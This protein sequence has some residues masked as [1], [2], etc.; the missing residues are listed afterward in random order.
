MKGSHLQVLAIKNYLQMK[1][2]TSEWIR[3]KNSYMLNR[4]TKTAKVLN[5]LELKT[6]KYLFLFHLYPYPTFL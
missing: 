1:S 5:I 6:A 3:N 4:K 2:S